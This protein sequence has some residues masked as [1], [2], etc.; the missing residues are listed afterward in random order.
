MIFLKFSGLRV[1]FKVDVKFTA[2]GRPD[3]DKDGR[4][5]STE[6]ARD[7]IASISRP[8]LQLGIYD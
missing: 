2:V 5:T 4:V 3:R 7:V 8:Y 1:Y 6:D